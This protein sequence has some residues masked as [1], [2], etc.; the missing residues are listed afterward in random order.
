MD[1]ND[2]K[3]TW[4]NSF[5]E[6]GLS[7]EQIKRRLHLRDK[8][9]TALGKL[10][11]SYKF[12][13]IVGGAEYVLILFGLFFFIDFL[14]A[15]G[16]AVI[17]SGLMGFS[18]WSAWNSYMKIRKT[19][20]T[21]GNLKEALSKTTESLKKNIK[22]AQ[23]KTLRYFIIPFALITGMAI[24]MFVASTFLPDKDFVDVIMSLEKKTI[25]KMILILVIG[26]G[27]MIPFSIYYVKKRFKK[28]YN[29]LKNALN[30]LEN[31]EN[32]NK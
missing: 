25:I 13:L 18:L 19:I 3:H 22:L 2:I 31:T 12:E 32:S 21:K 14:T 24:G 8:S 17:V 16:F 15:F 20:Y 23:N 30:D 7:E 26:S 4:K 9:N 6:K 5:K 29:D 1:F 28:H 10:K 11:K 27:T